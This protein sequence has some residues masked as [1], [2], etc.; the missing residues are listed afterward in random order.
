MASDIELVPEQKT[1]DSSAFDASARPQLKP[2]G[3]SGTLLN[4][5]YFSEEYLQILRGKQGAKVYDEIR[6]S[7]PQVVMLMN[8][9]MNPIKAALWEFEAP[10][11][12]A[13]GEK[14]RELMEFCAKEM[15]DWET[16]LHEAL[17]FLM[18]GY[19]LFEIIHTVVFN[20]PKF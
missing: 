19:S 10:S 7:E 3:S 20:H 17:T 18:F 8:A 1:N 4:G 16:H 14:H 15:I 9:V 2:I 12:V 13:D 11:N 5:G 6:R